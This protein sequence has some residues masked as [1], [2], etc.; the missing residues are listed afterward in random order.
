MMGFSEREKKDLYKLCAAIMHMGNM[1]F[2]QKPREEQ[3]EVDD[4]D[5]ASSFFFFTRNFF[6]ARI[7]EC[8]Q[9]PRRPRS[10]W[11]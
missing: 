10:C 1:N 7:R 11:G 2:K 8:F 9:R 4:V 5:R 6:F 3:A